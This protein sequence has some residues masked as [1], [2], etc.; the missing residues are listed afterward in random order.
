MN[1]RSSEAYS[2]TYPCLHDSGVCSSCA[3]NIAVSLNR[4]S[5]SSAVLLAV[6]KELR[7]SKKK[8]VN[9][10]DLAAFFHKE[11]SSCSVFGKVRSGIR[12]T[13]L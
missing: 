2:G 3:T 8:L 10:F 7:R 11:F 9:N 12:A 4:T 5:H 13:G 6:Q 1:F